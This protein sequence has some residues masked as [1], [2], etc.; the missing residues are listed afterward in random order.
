MKIKVNN[1]TSIT[2][3]PW[4]ARPC[5]V[6][7]VQLKREAGALE[8]DE[9]PLKGWRLE[10]IVAENTNAVMMVG[11]AMEEWMVERP[12]E[13]WTVEGFRVKQMA[14]EVLE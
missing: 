7:K 1:R 8:E 2:P 10:V 12:M 13:E 9:G 14:D 5:A 6:N 11:G 4:K 3:P